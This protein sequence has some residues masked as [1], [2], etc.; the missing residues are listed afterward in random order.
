MPGV[1]D[2]IVYQ[3]D[4]AD[5][6]AD[7]SDTSGHG[8]HVASIIAAQDGSSTGLVPGV[9]L[10]VL[11]VFGDDGNGYF[12]FVEQA[13]TWTI[14][15]ADEYNIVAVNMS[16]GDEANWAQAEGHYGI[17]DELIT[18]AGMNIICV[19][20]AGNGFARFDSD[21]G[22]AYPAADPNVISVGAVWDGDHGGPQW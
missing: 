22:L 17:S 11:K 8:S 3:Y 21:P 6:D 18:L 4:V 10:I 19:G 13:L 15:H 5:Q 16:F 9:D 7:A 20:A 14:N 2:R 12:S 1:A